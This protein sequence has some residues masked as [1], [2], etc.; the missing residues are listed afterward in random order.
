MYYLFILRQVICLF[1]YI[2]KS[3][4]TLEKIPGLRRF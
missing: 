4:F 2:G 1:V 3:L